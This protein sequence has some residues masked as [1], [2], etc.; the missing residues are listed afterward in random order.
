[1]GV[2]MVGLQQ[3]FGADLANW[4]NNFGTSAHQIA[5]TIEGTINASLQG[6]NQLLLDA[7]FRTGNW[8]QTV[9]GVERQ[10][11]NLFLTTLEQMALQ[12]AASLLGITTNTTAQV[13][14]GQA[15]AAAH[16]PA[17][18]AT[19]ISSYGVAALLGEAAAVAA[20]VAIMAAFG[21][22]FHQ[23]GAIGSRRVRRMHSGGLAPDEVPIIA[24]QGEVMIQRDIAQQPGVTEF[25][26]ALNAGMLFHTGGVIPFVPG[27]RYHEGTDPEGM[28]I[29]GVPFSF[30]DSGP[31]SEPAHLNQGFGSMA[32]RM[33]ES[34][35][36]NTSMMS[37]MNIASQ[38]NGLSGFGTFPSF[39]FSPFGNTMLNTFWV[40]YA[41][42]GN[43]PMAVPPG[44]WMPTTYSQDSGFQAFHPGAGVP[45]Q[46]HH[47]GGRIGGGRSI[48]LGNFRLPRF[49]GGGA[50]AGSKSMNLRSGEINLAAFVDPRAMSKWL[51]GRG[52]R[53]IIFDTFRGNKID[54][55]I[56]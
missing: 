30:G 43:V 44:G 24:Q 10:I 52:G 4:V 39:G 25:L 36:E 16:A 45:V 18:A 7:A 9:Q 56:R 23:G 46:A 31:W 15:I 51:E 19:S 14:S 38:L 55:G 40:N 1:M 20:I 11:L 49:H 17:A 21:G 3:P 33:N 13:A 22:A 27:R 42:V 8:K 6:T 37:L 28:T 53:R 2:K 47:S 32:Q 35:F 41:G 26:L 54:L 48:S 5:S 34:G 29:L 12:Q 50:M